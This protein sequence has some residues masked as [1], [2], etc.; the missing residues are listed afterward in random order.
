M[1]KH[2]NEA[3]QVAVL[4]SPSYGCGWSTWNSSHNSFFAMDKILVEMKLSNAPEEEVE[5]YCKEALGI[6]YVCMGGW[7]SVTI[8][9]LGEGTVFEITDNDGYEMIDI[10]CQGYLCA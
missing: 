6:D 4:V 2:K 1:N 5:K 3:G 8:V 7:E 9:Y 10:I